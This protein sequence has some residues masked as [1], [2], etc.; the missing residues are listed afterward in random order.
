MFVCFGSQTRKDGVAFWSLMGRSIFSKGRGEGGGGRG[1]HLLALTTSRCKT[2]HS[3][4]S[5]LRKT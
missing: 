3:T 1:E 2:I 4:F 5:A